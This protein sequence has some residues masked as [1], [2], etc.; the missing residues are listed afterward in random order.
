MEEEIDPEDLTLHGRVENGGKWQLGFKYTVKDDM[1]EEVSNKPL[2]KPQ[3]RCRNVCKGDSCFLL[4]PRG[5]KPEEIDPE[6]L[7]INGEVG[8]G[9]KWK[10]GFKYVVKDDEAEW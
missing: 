6:D 4:C 8:N 10:L 9:G 5:I 2:W 1:E 7:T 3:W